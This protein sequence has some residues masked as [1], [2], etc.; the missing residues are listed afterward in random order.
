MKSHSD[1]LTEA[2][3]R[4]LTALVNVFITI[5]TRADGSR[6]L[7][8]RADDHNTAATLIEE[9]KNTVPP[10]SL[11]YSRK[12]DGWIVS[13]DG[14]IDHWLRIARSRHHVAV[15]WESGDWDDDEPQRPITPSRPRPTDAFRALHLLDSAPTE[16]I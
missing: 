1:I 12:M 2:A 11:R 13:P 16:V 15:E 7:R 4:F 6:M 10:H 5:R 14:E 8:V 9:L 3:G